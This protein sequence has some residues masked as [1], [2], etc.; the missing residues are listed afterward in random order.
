MG[1]VAVKKLSPPVASKAKGPGEATETA[2]VAITLL[3]RRKVS[4]TLVLFAEAFYQNALA[5]IAMGVGV[6]SVDEDIRRH[7]YVR[8]RKWIVPAEAIH[9]IERD[10]SW[11]R[12]VQ[13]RAIDIPLWLLHFDVGAGLTVAAFL[14]E[15]LTDRQGIFNAVEENRGINVRKELFA[16]LKQPP[17]IAH[18]K[19]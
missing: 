6:A 14:K 2:D 16:R 1:A 7:D 3:P 12:V 15:L 19:Q 11:R 5:A 18:Q 9:D 10:R 13:E 4:G 17:R 8:L